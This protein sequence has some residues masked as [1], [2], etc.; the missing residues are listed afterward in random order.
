MTATYR[1]I[2]LIICSTTFILVL[3]VL[4]PPNFDRTT[5]MPPKP[6]LNVHNFPRPPLLEKTPRHLQVKWLDQT[7]AETKDAY[8]VLETTHPPSIPFR[9]YTISLLQ[10]S[11]TMSN[12][13]LHPPRSLHHPP[14][15]L[16]PYLL[17]RV[18]RARYLLESAIP[19]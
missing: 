3:L 18:E 19:Q 4:R 9:V 17:L 16:P 15:S 8:W 12:S 13:L 2:P 1:S 5:V 11:L 10:S 7:I 6:K 14:P